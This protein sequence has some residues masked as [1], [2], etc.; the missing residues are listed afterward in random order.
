MFYVFYDL[1]FDV[2]S[3]ILG[4]GFDFMRIDELGVG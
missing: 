4:C 1:F 2:E 3:I